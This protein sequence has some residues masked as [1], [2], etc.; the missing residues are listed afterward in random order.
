MTRRVSA[1]VFDFD[2]LILD[3][4]WPEYTSVREEFEAHGVDLRL[5]VWQEIVGTADHPHWTDQLE[6]RL[7]RPIDREVVVA[8]R[9]TRHHALIGEQQVRPGVVELLR[10]AGQA[11]I[12]VVVASSS[13]RSWVEGHLRR[14]GLFEH[15]HAV[16]GREDVARA[17]PAPDLFVSALEAVGVEP[18]AA[19]AFED[20]RHG[21]R[22][23]KAA[24]IYTVVVPNEITRGQSF[25]HADLVLE[26][27]L[28]FPVGRYL[29]PAL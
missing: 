2:G 20:S 1:L 12:A 8:R 3:T 23:A 5:E 11:R 21:S 14:L 4:E 29:A 16:R 17:K 19:V 10:A 15:F 18:G 9:R 7:G 24:G 25:E 26:S 28:D 13:S 22:A 27:L 6:A